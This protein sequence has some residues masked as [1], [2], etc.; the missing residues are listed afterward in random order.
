MDERALFDTLRFSWDRSSVRELAPAQSPRE[1]VS[2]LNKNLADYVWRAG[3]LAGNPYTL[4]EVKTL[5]GGATVGD[6]RLTDQEQILNLVASTRELIRMVLEERFSVTKKTFRHLNELAAKDEAR[7]WGLAG[8]KAS[9]RVT[10]PMPTPVWVNTTSPGMLR[11]EPAKDGL[12]ILFDRKL[13]AMCQLK[14]AEMAMTFFLSGAVE[15]YFTRSSTMTSFQMMNG[16]LLSSG[17]EPVSIPAERAGEFKEKIER[18]YTSR[19]A[20][21]VMA[22]LVDCHPSKMLSI[23]SDQGDDHEPGFSR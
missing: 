21:E 3:A 11:H 5:I 7:G 20:D 17:I 9:M 15:R 14:P 8:E 2:R 12:N 10:R 13:D 4:D 6:H 19:E 16:I 18:F 22:M 23:R 1:T